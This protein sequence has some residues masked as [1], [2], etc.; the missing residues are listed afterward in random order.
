MERNI[1]DAVSLYSGNKP[2]GLFVDKLYKNLKKMNELFGDI[3]DLY[4]NA[5]VEDF[6]KL[7]D[8]RTVVAKFASLF[9]EFNEYLEAA[10]I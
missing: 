6:S 8:D 9:R 5:G 3:K 10:K 7:P 4:K 1:N 2:I